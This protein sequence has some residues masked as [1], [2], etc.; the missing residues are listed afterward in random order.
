MNFFRQFEWLDA[1]KWP[2]NN[3]GFFTFGPKTANGIGTFEFQQKG[4]FSAHP[5]CSTIFLERVSRKTPYSFILFQL[6]S[7][8][9]LK[10][11]FIVYKL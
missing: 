8:P 11:K 4:Y 3:V 6:L 7:E 1:L 2:K 9:V 5:T 10:Q